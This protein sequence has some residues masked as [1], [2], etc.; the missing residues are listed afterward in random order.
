MAD[1]SWENIY[2]IKDEVLTHHRKIT[3]QRDN[4]EDLE[5]ENESLHL[6]LSIAIGRLGG[7]LNLEEIQEIKDIWEE[8]DNF[9]R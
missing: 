8:I 2:K 7:E 5:A 1:K 4:L 6:N 3:N 9:H